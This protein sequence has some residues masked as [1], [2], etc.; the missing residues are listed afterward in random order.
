M[1]GLCTSRMCT[2][3]M[4]QWGLSR[5]GEMI[6]MSDYIATCP[7][8]YCVNGRKAEA[9]A[10][11]A[12]E[13]AA[14]EVKE[15]P[16][17]RL[18]TREMLLKGNPCYDYRTQF[19]QRFPEGIQVTKELAVSQAADWDWD[20][21]GTYLLSWDARSTFRTPQ[22]EIENEY[23]RKMEPFWDLNN[24]VW[25]EWE[26][27]RAKAREEAR[28]LRLDDAQRYTYVENA[29][30]GARDV[31]NAGVF[32]A[33]KAAS[34]WQNKKLAALFVEL[35]LADEAAYT[36]QHRNDGVF[37]DR[38]DADGEEIEPDYENDSDDY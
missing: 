14:S 12:R 33:E 10:K 31:A 18:L 13:A 22:E 29:C 34:E 24:K 9:E 19:C 26:G 16:T 11:A 8:K 3:Q 28:Q 38:F 32:A 20:W 30:M 21:A 4:I 36:E 27:I 23:N 1:S 37:V 6:N 5:Q 35:F 25:D 2:F 15:V 17:S 7:C